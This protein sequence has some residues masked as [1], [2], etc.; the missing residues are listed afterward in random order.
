ML[1]TQSDEDGIVSAGGI[2]C[3]VDAIPDLGPVVGTTAFV[4]IEE[5]EEI[6]VA[7]HAEIDA[8]DEVGKIGLGKEVEAL[9]V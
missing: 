4:A 8:S 6:V 2:E 1:R 5:G 3:C 9:I 7:L